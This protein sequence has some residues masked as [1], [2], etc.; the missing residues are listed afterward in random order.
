MALGKA[1]EYAV[2]YW[3]YAMG[4]LDDGGLPFNR[5]HGQGQRPEPAQVTAVAARG[6]AQRRGPGRPDLPRLAGAVV[7]IRVR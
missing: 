5:G 7:G 1:L 3:P 2:K 4:A 6:D